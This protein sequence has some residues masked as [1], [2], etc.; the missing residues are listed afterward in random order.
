MAAANPIATRFAGAIDN[1][2]ITAAPA[3]DADNDGLSDSLEGTLGTDP[4]TADPA[5]TTVG[6]PF[7]F[8]VGLGLGTFSYTATGLPAGLS[9]NALTGQIT[10][11]PTAVTPVA[12]TV[13]AVSAETAAAGPQNRNILIRIAKGR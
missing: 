10:G 9:I 2:T 12:G 6:S 13:V 1:I 11:T 3:A 5:A 8:T 7:N 4:N